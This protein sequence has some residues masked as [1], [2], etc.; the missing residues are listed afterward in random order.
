MYWNV[1]VR[2][3]RHREYPEGYSV[4][5]VTAADLSEADIE[6]LIA[7]VGD[8]FEGY[9][10][11]YSSN[12]LLARELVTDGYR[13]WAESSIRSSSGSAYVLERND[14]VVGIATVKEID[15]VPEISEIEL[16]GMITEEQGKGLYGHLLHGVVSGAQ[17]NHQQQIVISTQSHNIKVQ[18]AWASSGFRPIRSI[19]T[20]HCVKR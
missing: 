15:S 11:H 8:S 19:E 7:A 1:D 16:A 18:R 14:S 5:K 3:Y 9:T 2:S 20:S 12:P 17:A 13:E 6:K 4:R 10:S